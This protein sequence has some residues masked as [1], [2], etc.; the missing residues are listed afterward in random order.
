MTQNLG[1]T[2]EILLTG[3]VAAGEF[4]DDVELRKE[5]E[6]IYP[7][8]NWSDINRLMKAMKTRATRQ[9]GGTTEVV[10]DEVVY[11]MGDVAADPQGRTHGQD[12][13]VQVGT[14]SPTYDDAG[15]LISGGDPIYENYAYYAGNPR[16]GIEGGVI[17]I[18]K[19]STFQREYL[20]MLNTA[21]SNKATA[22][23]KA[24]ADAAAPVETPVAPISGIVDGVSTPDPNPFVP[25]KEYRTDPVTGER[26]Q[27]QVPTPSWMM[28]EYN[29]R[30]GKSFPSHS[31]LGKYAFW[32]PDYDPN[33]IPAED[34]A[35]WT[36]NYD[37]SGNFIGDLPANVVD[38][39]AVVNPSVVV[40]PTLGTNI[41]GAEMAM[42]EGQGRPW[43]MRDSTALG[44]DV[45]VGAAVA[46]T[47][48]GSGNV[49]SSGNITTPWNAGGDIRP[50][51]N[52]FGSSFNYT[53]APTW[54]GTFP[55]EFGRY[56]PEQQY[57]AITA[58]TTP[59]YYLPGVASSVQSSYAPT[60]GQYLLSG[61]GGQGTGLGTGPGGPS[62]GE[63]YTGQG[64]TPR[65]I[66][67]GWN[68]A[69]G[70]SQYL[71]GST[72]WQDYSATGGP[73]AMALSQR[74]T[75]PDDI[76]AMALA[77][78]YGGATPR[79]TFAARTTASALG[80]LYNRYSARA[81]LQPEGSIAAAPSGFLNYL[82]TMNPTSWG[83][84]A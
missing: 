46:N 74:L 39:S 41:T 48:P 11:T 59:G 79:N 71:P 64:Q 5:L 51:A 29:E 17:H 57:Q 60:Y 73:G 77:R 18:P 30:I 61:Y 26:T 44:E 58:A 36:D 21:K 27:V 10:D 66:G 16:I 80:N 84:F 2:D 20:G 68:T 33:A 43:W 22:D 83:A 25:W 4:A 19:G 53:N 52:G 50:M 69:L 8:E 54:G 24:I 75:D 9:S 65:N 23:A 13:S 72:Q 63:W 47:W 31:F 37:Q 42:L 70:L 38:P 35:Y 3:R 34:S 6:K 81:A 56:T 82:S 32:H 15:N 12:V 7:T 76:Q 62:F 1:I 49:A 40:D 14:T 78:L 28:D 55:A 67:G 45:P